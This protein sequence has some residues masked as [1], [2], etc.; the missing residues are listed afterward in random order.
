MNTPVTGSALT[1]DFD[2]MR[3]VAASTSVRGDEIRSLLQGF[4]ARMDAV[5]S[6]VW[7][8]L[9]AARFKEVVQHWNTQSIRLCRSLAE[10]A[11]TIRRNEGDLR[12]AA[13]NHAQRIGDVA[14]HL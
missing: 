9:A 1:T 13:G 4:I 14:A 8:G 12:E 11:E 7:G 3:S 6:S 10:I 2:L 5:P